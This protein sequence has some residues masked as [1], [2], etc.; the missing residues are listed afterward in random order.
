MAMTKL[1]KKSGRIYAI[2]AVKLL[3]PVTVNLRSKTEWIAWVEAENE[4]PP[5]W[6]WGDERDVVI[7][8]KY[9][10]ILMM[11]SMRLR[12]SSNFCYST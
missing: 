9:F 8:I 4:A 3:E 5:I 1:V 2:I 11:S 6:R 12:E 10:E 7:F